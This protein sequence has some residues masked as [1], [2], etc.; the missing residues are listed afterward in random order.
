MIISS[1]STNCISIIDTTI[2]S[3]NSCYNTN[4]SVFG[5]NINKMH[6]ILLDLKIN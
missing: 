5:V 1:D 3:D 6:A 4:Y 2:I